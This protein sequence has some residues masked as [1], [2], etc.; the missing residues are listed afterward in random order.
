MVCPPPRTHPS[1]GKRH[2]AGASTSAMRVVS[3]ETRFPVGFGLLVCRR[4]GDAPPSALAFNFGRKCCRACVVRK[5]GCCTT[6]VSASGC[7]SGKR[8][9]RLRRGGRA[10]CASQHPLLHHPSRVRGSRKTPWPWIRRV[11]F[12]AA[13]TSGELVLEEFIGNPDVY[14]ATRVIHANW[15]GLRGVALDAAALVLVGSYA[16]AAYFALRHGGHR[17][18]REGCAA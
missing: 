8:K 5:M 16:G 15:V 7:V 4:H 1:M 10:G 13:I 14:C 2:R 18:C 3:Q 12:L 17:C 6:G 9:R 11:P